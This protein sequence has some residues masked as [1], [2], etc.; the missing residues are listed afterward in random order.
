MINYYLL[1]KPGIIMG[2]LFTVA[3][4]FILGSRG[5]F[6]IW[7][8]LSMALGI[9]LIMASGCVFNNYIDLAID[10]KMNR[11]KKRPLVQGLISERN[12]ILFASVIGMLGIMVLY[13]F[14]NV[15]TVALA[16]IGFFVYVVL[17]SYWKCYTVYGTAIG[18]VAGAIPPVVGYCAA[19]NQFDL[20]AAVLFAMLVL[21]QMPHFFS[22]ALCH[23]EDYTRAGIPVLPISHG[24]FR[25]KIHMIAYILFFI[26][27][28]MLLT[29]LGYTGNLFLLVTGCIGILWLT[30]GIKGFTCANDKQWG[31][32]MFVLSLLTIGAIC[33]MIPFDLNP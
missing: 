27:T 14:T 18:S 2:N 11:T 32:R 13:F 7:L 6:D 9:G 26:P 20:A 17:Y 24:I 4:G 16:S 19:S 1:T 15:L 12:A 23:L 31:R 3:A 21:W 30:L 5:H 28:A 22:I 33:L 8:F 10:R 25:T 29:L